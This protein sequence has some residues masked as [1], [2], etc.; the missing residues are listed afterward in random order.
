[1]TLELHDSVGRI[2]EE[3]RVVT[4]KGVEFIERRDMQVYAG[5]KMARSSMPAHLMLYK[6]EHTGIINHLVA[7]E[8]GH[9]LR[10]FGVPEEQRLVPMSDQHT[11]M[12]GL[13][14]IED[15]IHELSR[16]LPFG[17]L[18]K[19][20]NMWFD[21][22]VR[23]LTSFPSDM[24]IEQWLHDDYPEL[25][26]S[27]GASLRKQPEAAVQS[28][29]ARIAKRTPRTILE[30]SNSMNYAFF[31]VMS[32]HIGDRALLGRYADS[33]YGRKGKELVTLWESCANNYAGDIEAVRK[34]AEFL[35]LSRW[36]GWTDF[37]TCPATRGFCVKGVAACWRRAI[38]SWRR[39][40][41]SV[42]RETGAS[43]TP[44]RIL[45]KPWPW[46]RESCSSNSC[47]SVLKNPRISTRHGY[48]RFEMNSPTLPYSSPTCAT[49]STSTSSPQFEAK[50]KP[51]PASTPSR[52][53]RESTPSQGAE[54]MRLYS[55]RPRSSF[56][57]LC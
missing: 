38:R 37:G 22:L 41:V 26:V 49:C 13:S 7:H 12:A 44:P 48:R 54:L 10:L 15:E 19:V 21:G 53:R 6:P 29:T 2:L 52:K 46:R 45:L 30:A 55:A 28:L 36:F 20:V 8:C 35:G 32:N 34:W 11:K 4:G 56:R 9:V 40:S 18:A 1:M 17:S 27:Q 23:Q 43:S 3:V 5:V 57:T 42:M 50:L 24:R 47:G 39:Y 33:R 25:S 31:S 14:S 16:V 51:T